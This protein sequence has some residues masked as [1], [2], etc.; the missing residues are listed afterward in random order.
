MGGRLSSS[1]WLIALMSLSACKL[2]D[3]I[4]AN[5]ASLRDKYASSDGA[6]AGGSAGGGGHAGDGSASYR[7]NA[8]AMALGDILKRSRSP[9]DGVRPGHARVDLPKDRCKSG[10]ISFGPVNG[11]YIQCQALGRG[12]TRWT[13]RNPATYSDPK[14]NTA[15]FKGK[16]RRTN[17]EDWTPGRTSN[18]QQCW[19]YSDKFTA[20]KTPL[21][22]YRLT[23]DS[24]SKS[25][26]GSSPGVLM[27]EGHVAGRSDFLVH[28]D[29]YFGGS[30]RDIEAP[31]HST[32]GCVKLNPTCQALFVKFYR[33]NRGVTLEVRER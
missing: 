27:S 13:A 4:K 28:S 25:H 23:D 21:G 8:E 12:A 3:A 30:G 10:T 26:W 6:R 1:I 24:S 9:I 33:Q 17:P 11:E 2:L 19:V 7:P 5:N 16:Y 32:A 15:G 31:A 29:I 14:I 20:G 18:G 22:T